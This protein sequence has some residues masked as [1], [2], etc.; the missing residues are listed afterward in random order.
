MS[1]PSNSS[2]SVSP[3]SQSIPFG[4]RLRNLLIA[5]VSIALSVALFLGLRTEVTSTSLPELA[6]R[7]TPLEVALSNHKP[8]L[9]EFYANWC[10]TCQA[11]T[12]D[13][14]TIQQKYT[15][16]LNF[17]MLN[18]DNNKWL[19]EILDYRVDGI[20]HFVFLNAQAEAV[21]QTI[22]EIPRNIMEENL[23]ALI[24]RKPLPHAQ[25]TGRTSNFNAPVN[26]VDT[27][28]TDPRAHGSQALE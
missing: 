14:Q 18:V 12:S 15:D 7:S 22:G 2:N 10:T 25:A 27:R 11:M 17:V 23:E 8:T 26:V 6:K 3:S 5:L 1:P 28:S 9:M 21:A 19:P 4:N 20:P 24:A 13:M 16:Q